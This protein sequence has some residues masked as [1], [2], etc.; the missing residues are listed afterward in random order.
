[1][2]TAKAE[3]PKVARPPLC[4]LSEAQVDALQAPLAQGHIR[5][6][7]G[8][9]DYI[10]GHHAIREANRIFGPTGWT[11]ETVSM[12]CVYTGEYVNRKTNATGTQVAYIAMIRIRARTEEGWVTKEGTGYGDGIDYTSPA[13]AHES[14]SKEAETDAMKRALMMFGDCF[15]LALYDKRREHV[16]DGNGNGDQAPAPTSRAAPAGDGAPACPKCGKPM[17]RRSGAKGPFWGCSG[18]KRD[19][20]GCKETVNIEEPAEPAPEPEGEDDEN[21]WDGPPE[22]AA[23]ALPLGDDAPGYDEAGYPLNARE[24]GAW[25]KDVLLIPKAL[26]KD[27]REEAA[28]ALGIALSPVGKVT[29][30]QWG[31][32]ARKIEAR[33][34]NP[35][36]EE[37]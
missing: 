31:Q 36:P 22:T 9:F 13:A 35:F 10:E 8:K 14:A 26:C 29:A 17:V 2:A 32:L 19:G 34:E 33:N 25:M 20:T 3:K 27:M 21:P 11:R 18:W 15:G 7:E 37:A 12:E 30:E 1:M 4:G 5:Q 6:R 24:L 16:D 28:E 23:S